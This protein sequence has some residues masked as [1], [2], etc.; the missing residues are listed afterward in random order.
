MVSFWWSFFCDKVFELIFAAK[1]KKLMPQFSRSI[2]IKFSVK[3]IL[4]TT[5]EP[6]SN[7][8]CPKKKLNMLQN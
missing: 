1:S 2:E 3:Y 7:F 6:C 4:G 8:N 5:M